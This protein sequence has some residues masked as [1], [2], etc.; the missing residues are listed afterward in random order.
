MKSPLSVDADRIRVEAVRVAE[1]QFKAA[2]TTQ[3]RHD[4]RAVLARA[5]RAA[6]VIDG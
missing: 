6:G 3:Q 4:A 5:R 1:S 2:R